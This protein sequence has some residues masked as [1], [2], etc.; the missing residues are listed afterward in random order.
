MFGNSDSIN[1]IRSDDCWGKFQEDFS[2]NSVTIN[3]DE[4]CNDVHA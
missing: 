3:L 2:T 4:N 1:L